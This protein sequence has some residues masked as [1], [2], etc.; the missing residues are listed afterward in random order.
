IMQASLFSSSL[1]VL[2]NRIDR[3]RQGY[4]FGVKAEGESSR[5]SKISFSVRLE[6][7]LG[8][9]ERLEEK[10]A[11][12]AHDLDGHGDEVEG[13]VEDGDALGVEKE[14][15]GEGQDGRREHGECVLQAQA[16][17]AARDELLDVEATVDRVAPAHEGV[18]AVD[19]EHHE[20]RQEDARPDA[21]PL[22]VDHVDLHEQRDHLR[23]AAVVADERE[24]V[25]E[26]GLLH[27]A[28]NAGDECVLLSKG[29][30]ERVPSSGKDQRSDCVESFKND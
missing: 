22:R 6:L 30:L 17:V 1:P 26:L 11:A 4:M 18:V 7:I 19:G 2:C 10:D 21:V 25:A 27:L 16:V 28:C 8:H 12:R 13:G 14:P 3:D 29:G 9:L 23:E 15:R 24:I 20:E 5:R